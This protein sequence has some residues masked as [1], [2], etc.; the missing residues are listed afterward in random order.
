MQITSQTSKQEN[1]D[2][3]LKLNC[4]LEYLKVEIG[5]ALPKKWYEIKKEEFLVIREQY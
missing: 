4:Q 5:M 3:R 1:L 2:I